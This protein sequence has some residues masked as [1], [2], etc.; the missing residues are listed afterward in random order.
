MRHKEFV[1]H[2]NH[3]K[4]LKRLVIEENNDY[5]YLP[6]PGINPKRPYGNSYVLDDI[7][8]IIDY[9][10]NPDYEEWSKTQLD[11]ALAL[12]KEMVTVLEIICNT[13]KVATGI[14]QMPE[15]DWILIG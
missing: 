13:A 2:N 15:D 8:E 10:K 14:Y 7:L 3:L 11:Y 9:E 6:V 1:I 4:L 5:T 12:H